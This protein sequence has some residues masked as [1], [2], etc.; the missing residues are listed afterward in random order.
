MPH[1]GGCHRRCSFSL[2]ANRTAGASRRGALLGIPLLVASLL[3]LWFDSGTSHCKTRS[4]RGQGRGAQ[5]FLHNGFGWSDVRMHEQPPSLGVPRVLGSG[6]PV[7][8]LGAVWRVAAQQRWP[9]ATGRSLVTA[10]H[11]QPT[12]PHCN[13]PAPSV[14]AIVASPAAQPRCWQHSWA[15]ATF[16]KRSPCGQS[17]KAVIG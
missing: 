2:S 15:T 12:A 16:V 1:P 6:H 10:Q 3:G 4:T 14:T 8:Q 17:V 5:G 13:C 11:L 7:V 9:H